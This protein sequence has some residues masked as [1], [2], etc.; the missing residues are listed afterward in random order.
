[1][2]QLEAAGDL[3]HIVRPTEAELGPG[4]GLPKRRTTGQGSRN[5]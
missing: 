3:G 1:M 2:L 4:M 5:P